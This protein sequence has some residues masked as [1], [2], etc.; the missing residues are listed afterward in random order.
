LKDLLDR[1]DLTI[2]D[3]IIEEE[4]IEIEDRL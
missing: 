1:L 4:T 2:E 3:V